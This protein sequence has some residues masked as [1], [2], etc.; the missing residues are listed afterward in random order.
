MIWIESFPTTSSRPSDDNNGL[1]FLAA[2]VNRYWDILDPLLESR[3]LGVEGIALGTD[4][5][6]GFWSASTTRPTY[7]SGGLVVDLERCGEEPEVGL[8]EAVRGIAQLALVVQRVPSSSPFQA[9]G[10]G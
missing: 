2:Q 6:V 8:G 9:C 3:Q 1:R 5:A 7:C 4:E 10:P